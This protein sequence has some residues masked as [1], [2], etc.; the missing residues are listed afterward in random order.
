[1]FMFISHSTYTLNY[2]YL[3]H[4]TE[5]YIPWRHG[6]CMLCSPMAISWNNPIYLVWCSITNV[7]KENLPSI[8][9]AHLRQLQWFE[10]SLILLPWTTFYGPFLPL[11]LVLPPLSNLQ[12]NLSNVWRKAQ[13]TSQQILSASFSHYCIVVPSY[14]NILSR[15]ERNTLRRLRGYTK[16]QSMFPSAWESKNLKDSQDL[17]GPFLDL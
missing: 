5:I 8:A 17:Q 11:G 15:R 4:L 1:M 6:I 3:T 10:K 16:C 12:V 7:W 13:I 14:C 2:I 9:W